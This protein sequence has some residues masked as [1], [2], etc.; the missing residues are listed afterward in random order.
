MKAVVCADTRL[1][2]GDV[3]PW[4]VAPARVDSAFAARGNPE[5]HAKIRI[6]P[7]IS[8]ATL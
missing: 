3:P 1:K 7:E 6:H 8:T 4:T 2:V 5:V